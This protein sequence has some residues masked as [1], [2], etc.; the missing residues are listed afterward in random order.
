MVD[1]RLISK[2][3]SSRFM[4]VLA[5]LFI[6]LLLSSS[7]QPLAGIPVPPTVPELDPGMLALLG[8]SATVGYLAIKH[9]LPR[10]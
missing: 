8:S 7:S 1:V 5:L 9:K 6:A 3:R 4:K 2:S 10:R